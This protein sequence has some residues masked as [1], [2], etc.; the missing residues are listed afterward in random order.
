[1]IQFKRSILCMVLTGIVLASVSCVDRSLCYFH[2][3]SI[4]HPYLWSAEDSLSF[5]FN[6]SD[7]QILAEQAQ[8]S[9]RWMVEAN[10]STDFVFNTLRVEMTRVGDSICLKDTVD[11]HVV[12]DKRGTPILHWGAHSYTS[13]T[14]DFLTWNR[15]TIRRVVIRPI[16]PDSIA[17]GGNHYLGITDIGL[18]VQRLS[19]ER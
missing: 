17:Y 2:F 18:S 19:S 14:Y 7:Q 11:M 8:P 16:I 4:P 15:D 5:D 13:D 6:P 3:E 12:T 1:M 9:L 10:A